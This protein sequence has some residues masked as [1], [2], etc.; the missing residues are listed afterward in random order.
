MTLARTIAIAALLTLAT[1]AA[2]AIPEA[3]TRPVEP[4]RIAGNVYYVGT[5]DL[6]SFLIAGDDGAILLDAP[7]EENAALILRNVE[8]L[9]FKPS[10]I[11]IL[12]NSH[13]HFDHAGGFAAVLAKTHAKLYMSAP[14]AELAARGGRNDF[15]F[16]D[17]V[18]YAPVTAD[19]VVRD[20]DVVRLGNVSM[21][22]MITPGHTKG[23]TTWRTSVVENGKKLDVAFLCSVTAPGYQLVGNAKYPEIMDDYRASFEKLRS[24]HPDV[25]LGNHGSFFDLDGKIARR[26]EAANPFVDRGA[27]SAYLDRAW[28]DLEAQ[29][30][31]Q[32]R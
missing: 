6:G 27:W 31:K 32:R 23:C 19:R 9:G 29:A 10:D 17:S 8:K 18:P 11:R 12:V 14:D 15:A 28:K 25:F 3:W 21:T 2:A 13:A 26:G 24:I 4:F 16:G 5:A 20:G 30:E 22:A 7:L 1:S